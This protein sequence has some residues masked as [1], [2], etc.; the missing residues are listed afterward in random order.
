LVR[1]DV[2]LVTSLGLSISWFYEILPHQWHPVAHVPNDLNLM[3]RANSY[4]YLG[5]FT[6]QDVAEVRES[7]ER[8]TLSNELGREDALDCSLNMR[9]GG[10]AP[11]LPFGL[12]EACHCSEVIGRCCWSCYAAEFARQRYGVNVKTVPCDER[13]HS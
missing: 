8:V 10:H 11:L 9:N 2:G 12:A 6:R 7:G 13:L 5:H 1:L 4:G 3:R